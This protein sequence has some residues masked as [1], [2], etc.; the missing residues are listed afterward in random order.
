MKWLMEMKT[1]KQLWWKFIQSWSNT[2]NLS[3]KLRAQKS[4]MKNL[5]KLWKI[6]A[7]RTLLLSLLYSVSEISMM[8]VME[9]YLELCTGSLFS[10][11]EIQKSMCAG[12]MEK[13]MP[14]RVVSLEEYEKSLLR[15][16]SIGE[17]N[18]CQWSKFSTVIYRLN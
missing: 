1:R 2:L 8:Q 18:I 15:M 3:R 13:L 5:R 4:D 7:L 11:E 12:F 17:V 16:K 6:T 10:K 14:A 9:N